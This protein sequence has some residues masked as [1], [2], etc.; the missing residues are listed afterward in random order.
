MVVDSSP[1]NLGRNAATGAFKIAGGQVLRVLVMVIGIV[2]LARLLSPADY[3]LLAMVTAIIGIGEILRDF[4]LSF[5]AIQA[6]T[7][8]R[9]ERDNLF[10]INAG[11]GAL[12][13]GLVFILAGPIAAF[14]HEPRLSPIVQV[15]SLTFVFSGLNTQYLASL[16]RQQRFGRLAIVETAGPLVGLSVG[17]G[18]ALLDFGYWSLVSQQLATSVTSLIA[19]AIASFWVPGLYDRTIPVK[20]FLKFGGDVLATQLLSY[21]GRNA[22]SVVIGAQFGASALGVYDRAFQL[23]MLPLNQINAPATKVAL[24]ILSTLQDESRRFAE[25]IVRGQL[26]LVH[27]VA[28]IILFIASQAPALILIVLGPAWSSSAHIL[29]LL[30]LGG[31]AQAVNYATY[32]VFLSKGLTRSNFYYALAT[33]PVL[34]LAVILGSQFGLEGVAIS[35]SVTLLAIWPF[36]L[37][38]IRRVSDAPAKRMFTTGVRA[39]VAYVL[40]AFASSA[41]TLLDLPNPIAAIVA[42]AT[43]FLMAMGLLSLIWRGFRRDLLQVFDTR[44]FLKRR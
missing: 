37:W 19:A 44:H 4:G 39:I 18:F 25:Y 5:A 17:I 33:R 6:K 2:V 16:A 22:D 10:W 15:L 14:Y 38:W 32:W 11:V 31:V 24:P 34:V 12:L 20:R 35:Y 7:L 21:A 42:G 29:Q 9:K 8:S 28:P 13:S 43:A 36:A 30:A 23:L 26:V 27:A 41:V 3:G 40:C 1:E